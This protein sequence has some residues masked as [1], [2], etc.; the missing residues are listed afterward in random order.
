MSALDKLMDEIIEEAA[1]KAAKLVLEQLEGSQKPDRVM[2]VKEAA[3]YLGISDKLIYQLCAEKVLPHVKAGG[4]NS[5]K[6]RILFRQSTLDRW[7]RE[8]EEA[9]IQKEVNLCCRQ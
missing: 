6:P 8:Q 7:L 5:N 4:L 1:A 9:S 2:D 3:Q